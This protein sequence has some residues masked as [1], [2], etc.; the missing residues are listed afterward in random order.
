MVKI[1]AYRKLGL[2]RFQLTLTN[3][4][5]NLTSTLIGKVRNPGRPEADRAGRNGMSVLIKEASEKEMKNDL[6]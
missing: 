2:W 1:E 6:I 4:S 3:F 5:L